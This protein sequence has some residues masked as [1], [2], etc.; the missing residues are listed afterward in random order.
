MN[1]NLSK[2]FKYETFFSGLKDKSPNI[3]MYYWYHSQVFNFLKIRQFE[4]FP[5]KLCNSIKMLKR[6]PHLG[7]V[8][9]F[10]FISCLSDMMFS[11]YWSRIILSFINDL[12][13]V[14]FQLTVTF[15]V[16]RSSLVFCLFFLQFL[17]TYDFDVHVSRFSIIS[18]VT[19]GCEWFL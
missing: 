1:H 17:W 8:L 6:L 13:C 18:M 4:N 15:I 5:T 11:Q 19:Q 9:H 12:C 7:L 2:K 14:K 10:D 3:N 16:L